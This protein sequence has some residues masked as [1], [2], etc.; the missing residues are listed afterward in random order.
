MVEY[1]EE[2]IE[3]TSMQSTITCAVMTN[4][5]KSSLV[6]EVGCGPGK[7]SLLIA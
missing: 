6:L 2:N 3:F 4:T 5:Q 1:Y 7:H